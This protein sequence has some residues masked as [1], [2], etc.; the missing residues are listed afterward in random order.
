M[1]VVEL[2]T[3]V[4]SQKRWTKWYR[5]TTYSVSPR[6]LKTEATRDASRAAANEW[7][8]N[9]QKQIDAELGEAAKHPTHIVQAYQK[10]EENHRLYAKWQ[11]RY[12]TPKSA[13]PSEL[14]VEFLTAALASSSPPFPLEK[15]QEDP[16]AFSLRNGSYVK[17]ED[18]SVWTERFDQ[19]RR[20]ESLEQSVPRTNTI[21]AHIDDYLEFRR[22]RVAT[23]KNTLGTYDT[24]KGRLLVFRKWV[25]PSLPIENLNEA[26][27]ERFYVHLS[28]QVE[29]GEL[30]QSTMSAVQGATREFIRSRWE[31][32]L[33]ELPRNLTARGLA[34][35]APLQAVETFTREEVAT[36]FSKASE[37]ERLYLLL[38]LNCGFYPSDIAKLKQSEV[39]WRNGRIERKRSKT[40]G[41]SDKVPVIQ[42]VLWS[43]TLA[44]LRKHRSADPEYVLLNENGTPLWKEQVSKNG[45][46][47]RLNNIKCNFFRLQRK[48][49]ITKGLKL[50]RKTGA[51]TMEEHPEYGRYAE[52]F[53]GEVPRSVAGRHYVKPSQDQFDAALRW[54][55]QQFG[56]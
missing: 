12:G 6:K 50:F 40:R 23:G 28:K 16:L 8:I 21:R 4:K 38:M 14:M 48:T 32:R 31:R 19:L 43:E 7:W 54:V 11:R 55:G 41:R 56:F 39:D 49:E 17:G 52:H 29:A 37:R 1:P 53:L 45:K 20:E 10:A 30:S 25:D 3:W 33:I 51:S 22:T 24:Y 27:W 35:S 9:R 2:M 18:W 5:G 46:F 36:L 42:Y 13:E 34:V 47:N 44:L 15:Y 26:L